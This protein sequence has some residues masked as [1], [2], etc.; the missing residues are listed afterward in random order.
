MAARRRRAWF[1]TDG[2]RAYVTIPIFGKWRLGR[3]FRIRR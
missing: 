2:H 1:H 3:G